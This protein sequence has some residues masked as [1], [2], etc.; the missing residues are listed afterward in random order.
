M[1]EVIN[2]LLT[3][4]HRETYLDVVKKLEKKDLLKLSTEEAMTHFSED[5]NLRG[6]RMRMRCIRSGEHG[7][8]GWDYSRALRYWGIVIWQ[9]ISIWKN[10]WICLFRLPKSYRVHLRAGKNWQTVTSMDM[11]SGRMKQR[12]M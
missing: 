12:T 7:M 1:A 11:R 4:G 8:D 10:V 9:T 3:K 2:K 6:I 5:D